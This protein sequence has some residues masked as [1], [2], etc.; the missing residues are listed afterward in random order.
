[1]F[2]FVPGTFGDCPGD[3]APL[4]IATPCESEVDV[5]FASENV[6][7]YCNANAESVTVATGSGVIHA[8]TNNISFN[9]YAL[10]K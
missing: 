7:S 8:L 10:Q 4:V 9:I 2:S 6:V 5:T 1:M 3:L